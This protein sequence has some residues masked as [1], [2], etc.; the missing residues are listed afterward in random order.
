[1][2]RRFG[3]ECE[4][5][6]G[7]R[8]A[9]GLL[10]DDGLASPHNRN[11]HEYHCGCGEVCDYNS[12]WAIR[13]QYDCTVDGEL[14]TGILDYGSDRADTTV[15]GLSRALLRSRAA[16]GTNAGFHVHVDRTDLDVPAQWRL[17]RMFVRYQDDLAELASTRFHRVRTYNEPLSVGHDFW[18]AAAEAESPRYRYVNGS[19]LVPKRETFEFRLWNSTRA[20]WRMHLAT[21]VSVAMVEAA[22]DG[23]IVTRDTEPPLEFMLGDYLDDRTWAGIIRQRHFKS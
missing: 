13:G 2:S 3:F 21:G 14:I 7:A 1:M 8:T 9:L 11:L 12:P 19:W 23:L 5:A 22:N 18:S 6:A 17:Y 15:E 16:T 10:V 20:E 4:L